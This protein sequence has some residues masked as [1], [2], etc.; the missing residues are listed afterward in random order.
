MPTLS[1]RQLRLLCALVVLCAGCGTTRRTDT[2]RTATEQLLLADAIDRSVS[3]IDFGLLASKEIYLDNTYLGA[4]VDKEYIT[5]TLRQHMLAC[6][7]VLKDKKEDA[8]FVVE[9]RAGAVGT[10]RHDL[11]FGTPSTSVSLGAFSP[12]P[13]APPAQVPEIALAKR[14][15]QIGV[16]KIAVFAYERAT[17]VPVWQ[18]GSDV[19]ASKA[20]DL[21]VFGTGPYQ[22][23][24]IYG[25]T[26]FAGEDLRVPLMSDK[27]EDRPPVRVAR[28]RV[29]NPDVLARHNDPLSPPPD[30]AA[31]AAGNGASTSK[32]AEPAAAQA[33]AASPPAANRQDDPPAAGGVAPPHEGT[34]SRSQFDAVW[35]HTPADAPG[36]HAVMAD[37]RWP[38]EGTSR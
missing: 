12:V 26:K 20:R 27:N 36:A 15:D 3:R 4:A 31:S 28:E 17:G 22:R 35:T 32:P 19:V 30:V 9:V 24:N 29:L 11:L 13:G 14:T 33:S 7:C 34:A 37:R 1:A 2:T 5:S 21:W 25:G 10:D 6:G 16:A 8:D 23:G 18:S 38:P